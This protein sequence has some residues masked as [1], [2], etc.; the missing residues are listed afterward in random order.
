M[1]SNSITGFEAQDHSYLQIQ[2]RVG[3]MFPGDWKVV[4]AD[5]DSHYEEH[6]RGVLGGYRSGKF[7]SPL[8]YD[9]KGTLEFRLVRVTVRQTVT[10]HVLD[11]VTK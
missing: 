6:A 3:G 10:V 8:F 4:S 1:T 5:G 11:E 7:R 9:S 2:G